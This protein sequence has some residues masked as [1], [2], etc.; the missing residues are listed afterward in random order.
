MTTQ[1][2]QSVAQDAG[3][4]QSTQESIQHTNGTASTTSS[5]PTPFH[6]ALQPSQESASAVVP[7]AYGTE[8]TSFGVSTLTEPE[9]LWLDPLMQ[10][11]F[12]PWPN[13]EVI[14]RGALAALQARIEQGDDLQNNLQEDG[15]EGVQ[16]GVLSMKVERNVNGMNGSMKEEE[17]SV[18]KADEVQRPRRE[19]AEK[20]KPSVFAGLDLYDPEEE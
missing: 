6:P 13:E 17:N 3:T 18:V 11:P 19:E 10:A 9:K 7:D 2:A 1:S 20:P 14:R 8:K 16:G 5:F 12:L 4:Q 15:M